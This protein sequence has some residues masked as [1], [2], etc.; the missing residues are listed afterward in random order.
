MYRLM[1]A[2]IAVA[3]G[4][5]AS[6]IIHIGSSLAT[7]TAGRMYAPFHLFKASGSQLAT[8]YMVGCV[9]GPIVMLIFLTAQEPSDWVREACYNLTDKASCCPPA[10]R[11][12]R[13]KSSI[14]WLETE[15]AGSSDPH[16]DKYLGKERLDSELRCENNTVRVTMGSTI[17]MAS[18]VTINSDVTTASSLKPP[19]SA[20]SDSVQLEIVP[21]SL[22]RMSD[23]QVTPED[24]DI[25]ASVTRSASIANETSKTINT[26][27]SDSLPHI[28][29]IKDSL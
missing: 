13:R 1:L 14:P 6:I 15:G 9:V 23:I 12:H 25:P 10:F 5:T 4:S 8:R 28:I 11:R 7:G 26:P 27:R 17:T 22:R 19:Q 2:L 20:H 24:A 3:V 29:C 21:G 18:A 16:A